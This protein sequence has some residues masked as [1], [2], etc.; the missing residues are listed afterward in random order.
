MANKG[1]ARSVMGTLNSIGYGG[2][3]GDG[4]YGCQVCGRKFT[5][6]RVSTHENVCRRRLAS[7]TVKLEDNHNSVAPPKKGANIMTIG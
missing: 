1:A 6:D 4:R 3:S 2:P 7:G 5:L